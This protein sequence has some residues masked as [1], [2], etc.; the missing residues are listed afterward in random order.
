M[1]HFLSRGRFYMTPIERR[2]SPP[3]SQVVSIALMRMFPS[4][5]SSPE[6]VISFTDFL[7]L[8]IDIGVLLVCS[9]PHFVIADQA[10]MFTVINRVFLC[11][12]AWVTL[13]YVDA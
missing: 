12:F 8:V 3:H 9:Q 2:P 11:N 6:D 13:A 7:E 4:L 1:Q 5:E 10:L